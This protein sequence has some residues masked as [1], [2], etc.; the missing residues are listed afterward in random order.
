M[1][2]PVIGITPDYEIKETKERYYLN[3]SY[4]KAVIAGGGIPLILSGLDTDDDFL[5][6]IDLIDGLL[7]TGGNDHNPALYHAQAHEKTSPLPEKRQDYEL[8]IARTALT[9]GKPILGICLGC[10]TLNIVHE[11][12][13]IQDIPSEVTTDILHSQKE[14]RNIPTHK[15]LISKDSHLY[16][17]I[18]TDALLANSF[19]HQCVG[20]PGEKLSI[21]AQAEDKIIE[22]VESTQG[23]FVIGVQWHPEELIHIPEHLSLFKALVAAVKS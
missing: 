8:R 18:G 22:A 13:L 17:I 19:H 23:K 14:T 4:V 7:L 1:P 21:A 3:S 12:T 5:Q 11:G 9:L 20:Q 10:Q 2:K 15:V 6:M 16:R